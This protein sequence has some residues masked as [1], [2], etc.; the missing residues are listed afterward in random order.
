MMD[1]HSRPVIASLYSRVSSG[2]NSPHRSSS[3]HPL[4]S[5]S[6]SPDESH[7]VASGRDV[8]HVLRLSLDKD[9]GRDVLK[10]V[11]SVR[12][13]QV[14]VLI[15]LQLIHPIVVARN[16]TVSSVCTVFSNSSPIFWGYHHTP[17]IPPRE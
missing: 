5:V 11:R 3:S 15:F 2:A 14:S 13:S 17:S 7:A 10:E 16:L 6:L 8:L 9:I 1:V 4:S 12:I